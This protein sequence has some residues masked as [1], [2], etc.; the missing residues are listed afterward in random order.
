[1]LGSK[2]N[3]ASLAAADHKV[4]L[5]RNRQLQV[6]SQAQQAESLVHTQAT[7]A[8]RAALLRGVLVKSFLS[9]ASACALAYFVS[10]NKIGLQASVT[11][12][13]ISSAFCFAWATLGRLGWFGQSNKGDTSMERVD[14]LLFHAL[15]WLGM[16]FAVAAVL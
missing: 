8:G 1:M 6:A 16:Y 13:S 11:L 15:Y 10:V 4:E 2:S 14:Q 5:S 9:M 7:V 3:V 12:L